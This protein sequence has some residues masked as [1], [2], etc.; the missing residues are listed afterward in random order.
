MSL[1]GGF[2]VICNCS[3]FRDNFIAEW[4]QN[5]LFLLENATKRQIEE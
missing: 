5:V 2:F 3:I 1:F 4:V